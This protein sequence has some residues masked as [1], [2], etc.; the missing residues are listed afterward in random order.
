MAA[1]LENSIRTLLGTCEE[2]VDDQDQR[3]R[4]QKYIKSL[5]SMIQELDEL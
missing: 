2:I 3:W 1:K 5:D 4:L